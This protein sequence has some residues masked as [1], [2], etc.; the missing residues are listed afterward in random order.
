MNVVP[1]HSVTHDQSEISPAKSDVYRITYG[2]NLKWLGG[3]K[4]QS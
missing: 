1:E 4:K 3:G 2:E